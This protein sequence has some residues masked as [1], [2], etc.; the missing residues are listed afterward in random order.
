MGFGDYPKEYNPSVHGPYDPARYY[1]PQDTKFFDLKLG[2]VGAWFGRRQKT[3]QALAGAISRCWWRWQHNYVHPKRTGI[4]PFFQLA[5]GGMV[6]FYV[7]NYNR[8]KHHKNY[9]YH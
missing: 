1:G 8:L 9:K 2:E 4:A 7:L 6:F 3:P 5:V